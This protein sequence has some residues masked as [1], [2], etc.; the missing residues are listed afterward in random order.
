MFILQHIPMPRRSLC[1]K[2]SQM[3]KVVLYSSYEEDG[4]EKSGGGSWR[5]WAIICRP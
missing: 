5:S 3:K 1:N 2:T 4:V